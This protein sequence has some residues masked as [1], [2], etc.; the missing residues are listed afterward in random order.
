[1]LLGTEK[2]PNETSNN[3]KKNT[4]KEMG[5]ESLSRLAMQ[6]HNNHE[7]TDTIVCLRLDIVTHRKQAAGGWTYLKPY[8]QNETHRR[9]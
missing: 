6:E 1:M 8:D 9:P 2:L 3:L 7:Y 4:A 5:V